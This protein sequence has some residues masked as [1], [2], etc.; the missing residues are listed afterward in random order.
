MVR[1]YRAMFYMGIT[2]VGAGV[3][4]MSAVNPALGA[5]FITIGGVFM[6]I[7]ARNKRKW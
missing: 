3:V 5:G 1:N 2:F 4:F 6:L 7:G